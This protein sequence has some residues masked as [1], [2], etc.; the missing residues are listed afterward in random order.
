MV[1]HLR[2]KTNTKHPSPESRTTENGKRLEG[3]KGQTVVNGLQVILTLYRDTIKSLLGD[4]GVKQ[5]C[6]KLKFRQR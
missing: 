5:G 4:L 6:G 1:C 3:R 2:S